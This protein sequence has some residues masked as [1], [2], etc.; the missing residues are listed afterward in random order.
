VSPDFDPS[1]RIL[2]QQHAGATATESANPR[3]QVVA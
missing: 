2:I 1:G 3:T